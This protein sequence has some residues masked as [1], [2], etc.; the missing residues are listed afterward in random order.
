MSLNKQKIVREVGRR[1]R[2][3]NRDVQV[4]IETMVEV[5]AEE[6]TSGGRI[7]LEGFLTLD[8]QQLERLHPRTKTLRSFPRL[9]IRTGKRLRSQLQKSQAT[10]KPD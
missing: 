3:K 4:V 8:V 6:L 5:W 9:R 1:T 7:E 2:L 10:K